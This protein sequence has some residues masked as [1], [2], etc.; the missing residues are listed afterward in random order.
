MANKK[1]AARAYKAAG[2]DIEAGYETV[3]RIRKYADATKRPGVLGGLGSFGAA[4]D[5]SAAGYR[6]PVLV[7]GTD[8]VGTKL[9]LAKQ[10]D[11][12]DVAGVD[13]VAMCVNDVVA[14]GAEPLFFLDYLACGQLEPQKAEAIV[15]GI[16]RGLKEA[17]AALIGGETAEMPGL[18]AVGDYDV[19]GF[20]VGVAEKDQLITGKE[21]KAGDILLGLSANGLHS[22]GYS[23][24]RKIIGEA[25]LKRNKIYSPLG[26]TLE[27][28]L[29]RPTRIYVRSVLQAMQKHHIKGI[30]PIT[31]GGFAENVP[32]MLPSGLT[33]EI[34]L[35]SWPVPPIFRLLQEAG[36]L[37]EQD[38]LATLNM[39]IGLVVCVAADDAVSCAKTFQKCGEQVHVIGRVRT[40]ENILYNGSVF[41]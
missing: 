8:G 41:S 14:Q 21:I 15:R 13:V 12:L 35:G 22:N 36:H 16:A 29:L 24:V 19:A 20:V 38:M 3:E 31:G 2:V 32:R 7:S 11:R 27:E 25:G 10:W 33:G 30:A 5:L 23:L 37:D 39:G 9:L 28:A 4:F 17:G 40:G 18:Y 34:D 26:E 1:S 6:Q